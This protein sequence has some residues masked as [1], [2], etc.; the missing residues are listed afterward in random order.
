MTPGRAVV[1][2]S[3]LAGTATALL[4]AE[5]GWQ[6][7]VLERH[8]VPGGLMQRYRR[9]ACWFDTG[10]HLVTDGSPDGLL[11]AILRRLG[12]LDESVFLAPEP[13]AQYVVAADGCAPLTVPIGLDGMLAAA[14]ARWPEQ[15]PALE[16][17]VARLRG[18]LALNPWLQHLSGGVAAWAMPEPMTV[19]AVLADSGVT[20]EARL[21]L[22]SASA[23]L[24]QR[25]ERCPFDLYA[26]FAGTSFAGGWRMAGGGDGLM[27]PL[28]ARAAALGVGLHTGCGAATIRHNERQ[29]TAVVDEQGREHPADLVVAAIHPHEVLRLTGPEGFRPSFRSR[30]DEVPDGDG[31]VLLAAELSCRAQVLG[32]SHHLL[33]LADGG[34]AYV[35]APDC[36]EAGLPPCLEA[37]VWVPVAEVSAWRSSRLGRRDPA[38]RVWKEAQRA[39]LL[40][41]LEQRFPGLAATVVRSWIAS[42]LTFRDYLGGRHGGAMG[43]SHDLEFLGSQALSPRNKLRN[44][45][46]AGQSVSHPGILG[47][48]IGACVTAGVVLGRDLRAEVLTVASPHHAPA[49]AGTPV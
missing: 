8:T 12:T 16:R 15:A 41:A 34:D 48:L 9:G 30:L 4:L 7:T 18:R 20:G 24:A 31:A 40:Q 29:A 3:G 33:R 49:P 42:P 37:M 6:V 21:L 25:A 44:L 11:R 27:R 38:Y 46:L 14:T 43:L 32:R 35:V 13:G 22:G 47:T 45:L 36:W 19:D 23:I 5:G 2:G 1:I 17:F 26:A 28:L 10:F 39:R